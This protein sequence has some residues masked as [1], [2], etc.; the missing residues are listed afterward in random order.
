MSVRTVIM[1]AL[2]VWPTASADAMARNTVMAMS[3]NTS[4][5]ST[6]SVSSSARRR[7]SNSAWVMMPLLDT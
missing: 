3:S 4:T 6:M 5:P 7:K 2:T 1:P